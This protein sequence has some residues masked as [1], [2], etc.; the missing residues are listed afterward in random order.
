MVYVVGMATVEMDDVAVKYTIGCGVAQFLNPDMKQ[1][2][3]LMN[4]NNHIRKK[5]QVPQVIQPN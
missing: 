1:Y 2:Q 5:T 4:N 3:K